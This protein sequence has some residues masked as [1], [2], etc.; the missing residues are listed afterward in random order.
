VSEHFR[1]VVF[2]GIC[3]TQWGDELGPLPLRP[4][5]LEASSGSFGQFAGLKPEL[6]NAGLM[7]WLGESGRSLRQ[8]EERN[9]KVMLMRWWMAGSR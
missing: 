8:H 4:L 7:P 9:R 5:L 1:M 3:S 6:G 2:G